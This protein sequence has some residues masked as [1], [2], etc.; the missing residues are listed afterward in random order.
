MT[1]DKVKFEQMKGGVAIAVV[2]RHLAFR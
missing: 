1:Y 2:G